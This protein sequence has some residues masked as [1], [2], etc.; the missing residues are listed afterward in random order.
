M[1]EISCGAWK[2]SLILDIT[3]SMGDFTYEF[4]FLSTIIYSDVW[5]TSFIED[6]EWEMFQVLLHLGVVKPAAHETLNVE[7]A[8]KELKSGSATKTDY[9]RVGGIYRRM[10]LCRVA[11][12]TPLAGE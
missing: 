4:L 12:E 8:A 3:D 9:L 5:H 1:A 10:S 6:S 11:D 7:H 2:W